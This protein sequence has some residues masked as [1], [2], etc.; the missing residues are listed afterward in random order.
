MI[1]YPGVKV[2]KYKQEDGTTVYIL[3]DRNTN[4]KFQFAVRS[5]AWPPGYGF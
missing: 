4:D 5:L 3:T 1:L 2:E